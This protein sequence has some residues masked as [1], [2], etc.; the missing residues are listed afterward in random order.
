MWVSLRGRWR[1]YWVV[2]V[3]MTIREIREVES[4]SPVDVGAGGEVLLNLLEVGHVADVCLLSCRRR[5][6]DEKG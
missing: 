5:K 6:E 3:I 4:H 1:A 2:R